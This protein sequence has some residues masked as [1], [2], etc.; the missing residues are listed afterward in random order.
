MYTTINKNNDENRVFY[1][2]TF[3]ISIGIPIHPHEHSVSA[4]DDTSP[5]RA[6]VSQDS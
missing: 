4:D 5:H 6:T 2:Q 3:E 1:T